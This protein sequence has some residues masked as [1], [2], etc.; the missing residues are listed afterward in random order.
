MTE[1][2]KSW[3][4]A[5]EDVLLLLLIPAS[6]IAAWFLP[7]PYLHFLFAIVALGLLFDLL[8]FFYHVMTLA[9]GKY[10]SGF[11]LVGLGFYGWFLLAYRRSLVAPQEETLGR[12]LLFKLLDLLLF[13]GLHVLF[14]LPMFFQGRREKYR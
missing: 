5:T 11:P 8:S 14:Q 6:S 9:T 1:R 4:L 3:S 10:M 12:I 2:Q 7:D 13:L